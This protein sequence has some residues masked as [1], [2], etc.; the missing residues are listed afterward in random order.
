M[1]SVS[2]QSLNSSSATL[3]KSIAAISMP[4]AIAVSSDGRNAPM[5]RRDSGAVQL[6]ARGAGDCGGNQSGGFLGIRPAR[7]IDPFAGFQIF[8]MAKEMGDLIAQD[9]RQILIGPHSG[10]KWMQ[11]IDRDG[12]DLFIGPL[13]ILHHQYTDGTAPYDRTRHHR[14]RTDDQNIDRVA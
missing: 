5:L 8:V 10:I 2:Y 1:C 6:S 3:E 14:S 9:R 7:D 4:F 11:L 12:D 13:L